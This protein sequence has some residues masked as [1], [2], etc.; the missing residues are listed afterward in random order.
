MSLIL[1]GRDEA[2]SQGVPSPVER[3]TARTWVFLETSRR[4]MV[5][6]TP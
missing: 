4:S 2:I 5:L 1:K 6:L 3:G